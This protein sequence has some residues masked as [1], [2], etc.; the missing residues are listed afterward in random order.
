M[1]DHLMRT[2]IEHEVRRQMYSQKEE[3]RNCHEMKFNSYN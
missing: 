3:L 2:A 1:N